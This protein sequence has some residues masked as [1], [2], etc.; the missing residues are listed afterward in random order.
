MDKREWAQRQ[1]VGAAAGASARTD[2]E[3]RL[4]LPLHC[5]HDGFP[6]TTDTALRPFGLKPDDDQ[7]I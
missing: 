7:K 4:R 2:S 1:F 6:G 5:E 3:G